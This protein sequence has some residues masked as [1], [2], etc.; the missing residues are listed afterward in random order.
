MTAYTV[1]DAELRK[2]SI[3]AAVKAVSKD[4]AVLKTLCVVDKSNSWTDS[5]FRETNDD[6]TGGGTGSPLGGIPQMAPF[7]FVQVTETLVQ[8]LTRKYGD[9]SIISVEMNMM[10]TV[11]MLQR[12]IVRMARKVNWYI[13]TDIEYAMANSYGNTFAITAGNEWDSANEAARNPIYDLL[14]GIEMLRADGIN[15]LDGNGYLVVNGTDYTN[16]ISNSK[17]LNHPTFQSVSAVQNGVVNMLAGLKVMISEHITADTAFIVHKGTALIWKEVQAQQV[18]TEDRPGKWTMI[19]CWEFGQVQV[20]SP[21][22][23]CKITN[24]RK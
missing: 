3:D 20:Q 8:G 24:T 2:E 18:V 7:P 13:D 21:N 22:D 5:Y 23:I 14:Y 12:H 1:F 16:I 10:A 11:P 19:T 15:A 4:L 9:E 6:S 17:V